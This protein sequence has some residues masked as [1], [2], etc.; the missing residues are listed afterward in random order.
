MPLK[1]INQNTKFLRPVSI[2]MIY[3]FTPFN[4]TYSANNCERILHNTYRAIY[5]SIYLHLSISGGFYLS[6]Y[7][8][9]C[10]TLYLR[11]KAEKFRGKNVHMMTT[12]LL[13]ITLFTNGSKTLQHQLKKCMDKRVE[14]LLINLIY[15]H[16]M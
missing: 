13:W 6:V 8:S 10:S 2:E 4:H 3:G 14:V 7:Q 15:S 5:L 12:Y 1:S 16:Y 9:A 11:E